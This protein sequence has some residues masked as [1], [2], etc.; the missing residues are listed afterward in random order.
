L[1][2][3]IQIAFGGDFF[4]GDCAPINLWTFPPGYLIP[5]DAD[6]TANIYEALLTASELDGG[7]P[8]TDD[9]VPLFERWRDL[10]QEPMR[11][12][13]S[14]MPNPSGGY[15]TWLADRDSPQ[16]R[17]PQDVDLLVNANVLFCLGRRQR[18]DAEGVTEAAALIQQAVSTGRQRDV[19]QISSYYPDS[20]V[21]HYVVSRAYYEGGVTSLASAVQ[22]LADELEAE[23]RVCADGSVV[24]DRGNPPLNTAFAVL[25]LLNA[26]RNGS[27]TDGGARYLR[28]SQN[29]KFGFWSEA[30][31]FQGTSANEFTVLWSSS[32]LTTAMALEAL[33]RVQLLSASGKED[34][35]ELTVPRTAGTPL[36]GKVRNFL[37]S[38]PVRGRDVQRGISR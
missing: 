19:S 14:W 4:C 28:R 30:P 38:S 12:R 17:T 15:L 32:A 11:V 24:W 1:G 21:F 6:T 22:T 36:S 2:W 8:A 20:L 31:F 27:L 37:R 33:M 9:P 23:A 26:G 13:H 7:S 25:T 5:A 10:G 3:F 35:T 34:A 18:L 29:P 16:P